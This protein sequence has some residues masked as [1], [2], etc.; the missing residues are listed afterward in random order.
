LGSRYT[1]AFALLPI[2]FEI[3]MLRMITVVETG[4]FTTSNVV[5]V[6]VS[7]VTVLDCAKLDL[8]L[9]VNTLAISA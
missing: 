5:D 2:L 8:V 7:F 4:T 9:F 6:F 3:K 1:L